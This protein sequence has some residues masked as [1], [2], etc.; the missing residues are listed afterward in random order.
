M[1]SALYWNPPIKAFTL[2]LINHDVVWYGILFALG[3][4]LSYFVMTRLVLALMKLTES[5]GEPNL[6]GAAYGCVD[7]LSLYLVLTMVLFSRL[8]HLVFYERWDFFL[9]DPLV[10]LRIWEGGLAS[11]GGVIGL[12]LGIVLFLKREGKN[13]PFLSFVTLI[14]LLVVPSM[15]TG[16][17]IR[18]GNFVNQ[19][20]LGAPSVVPWA[21]IF[22]SPLASSQGV[23]VHPV[24]LYEAIVYA[25]AAISFT[26]MFGRYIL[27]RGRIAGLFFMTVFSARF[28]I[29]FFKQ[30]QSYYAT[31]ISGVN[32]GQLLSLPLI[33]WGLWLFY[34][35]FKPSQ[36]LGVRHVR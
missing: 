24:V 6:K 36:A 22:G 18:L 9:S 23:A 2:P 32:V 31:L 4:F 30:S 10:L 34:Q 11:H 25:I 12:L 35:S 5:Q 16:V 13:Y 26:L 17:F 19:E 28:I 3:I 14:D 1:L 21:V 27:V 33:G 20:I 7:K 15:V 8:F 29:E